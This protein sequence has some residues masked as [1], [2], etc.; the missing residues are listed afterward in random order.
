MFQKE[1]TQ[2]RR[3]PDAPAALGSFEPVHVVFA[4]PEA[5][6]KGDVFAQSLE[7]LLCRREAHGPARRP[8]A[9]DS[10]VFTDASDFRDGV[11][12]RALQSNPGRASRGIAGEKRLHARKGSG[13]PASVAPGGAKAGNLRFDD[14]HSQPGFEGLQVVG[15]PES[16]VSGAHDRH[17]ELVIGAEL[18]AR[19]ERIRKCRVPERL[20][21]VVCC[22]HGSSPHR[23]K[24]SGAKHRGS[25]RRTPESRTGT[26]PSSRTVKLSTCPIVPASRVVSA[27]AR[28]NNS[29][30]Q[31]WPTRTTASARSSPGVGTLRALKGCAKGIL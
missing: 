16:R 22:I 20:G 4:K 8:V 25:G 3:R 13:A 12:Q 14:R 15:G 1:A 17:V 28:T 11:E 6:P 2:V 10:F 5:V 21:A 30:R 23:C 29:W 9:I 7:L 31:Q 24:R 18:R 19:L 27:A 26:Q